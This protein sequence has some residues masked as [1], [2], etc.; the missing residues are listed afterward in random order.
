MSSVRLRVLK[1]HTSLEVTSIDDFITTELCKKDGTPDLS[2]SVFDIESE[3]VVQTHAEFVVS[4]L[5]PAPSKMRGGLC[6]HDCAGEFDATPDPAEQ[7][8]FSYSRERHIE[9]R[10]LRETELHGFAA[11]LLQ[12]RAARE[13]STTHAKVVEYGQGRVEEGDAEW[14]AACEVVP[15]WKKALVGA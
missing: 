3:R 1:R 8:R 5:A 13:R 7:I 4:F 11:Q 6:I 10:F 9:L 15:K 14:T 2:L 12:E